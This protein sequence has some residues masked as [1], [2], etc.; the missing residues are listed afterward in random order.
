MTTLL[1]VIEETSRA[2]LNEYDG[3]KR[4]WILWQRETNI[5]TDQCELFGEQGQSKC[6]GQT[7]THTRREGSHLKCPGK[8]V[9]VENVMKQKRRGQKRRGQNVKG[10]KRLGRKGRELSRRF[11]TR[12]FV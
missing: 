4:K 9:L 7:K 5:T 3:K 12:E 11:T 8:N 2:T 6:L 1:A 10:Q